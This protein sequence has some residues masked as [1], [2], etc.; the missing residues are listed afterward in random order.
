MLVDDLR[1]MG[2]KH[3]EF[4]GRQNGNVLEGCWICVSGHVAGNKFG[5]EAGS[6]LRKSTA[7]ACNEGENGVCLS[8]ECSNLP[9]KGD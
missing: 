2:V 3:G 6:L 7:E 5:L 4:F 1:D 8:M 9:L